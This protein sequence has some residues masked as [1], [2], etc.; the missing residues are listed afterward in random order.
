MKSRILWPRN[1]LGLQESRFI[2]SRGLLNPAKKAEKQQKT[3]SSESRYVSI[4]SQMAHLINLADSLIE[5]EAKRAINNHI[6]K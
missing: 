4:N 6:R 1:S 3:A 2:Y 5:V